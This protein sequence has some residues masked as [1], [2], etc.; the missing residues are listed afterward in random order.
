MNKIETV[1]QL[2]DLIF[3]CMVTNK[4]YN[5]SVS[6]ICTSLLAGYLGGRYFTNYNHVSL[7]DNDDGATSTGVFKIDDTYFSGL[8]ETD[9]YGN[10]EYA[11]VSSLKVVTPV[12]KTVTTFE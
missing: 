8:I 10:G 2:I 7:V 6:S 5:S 11:I 4:L 3:S 9:S 1:D 12:T